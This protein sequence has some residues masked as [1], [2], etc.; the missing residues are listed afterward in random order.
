MLRS[1][2]G[3][4]RSVHEE[5]GSVQTWEVRSVNGRHLDIKWRLPTQAR[6]F[7]S[8]F[9]KVVRDRKSVV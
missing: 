3:F 7:E 8:Q 2:T 5:E 6:S 1:M 4:G 9:E